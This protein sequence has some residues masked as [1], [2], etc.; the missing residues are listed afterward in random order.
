MRRQ[1]QNNRN[2]AGN[3]LIFLIK[4]RW[5]FGCLL[6]FCI[7][8]RNTTTIPATGSDRII[9]TEDLRAIDS[10]RALISTGDIIFRNGTDEVSAAARSFN[11]TDTNYSH[12][13]IIQVEND[14]VFVYHAI[15]GSY[16]PDKKLRR[17]PIDS[18]CSP[19]ENDKFA[20]YR[21]ALQPAQHD[22]LTAIVTRYYRAGLR[23]DMYFNYKTDNVMYCSEFVFKCLNRSMSDSLTPYLRLTN[24]YFDVTP[25]D[26]FLNP[27]STLIKRVDFTR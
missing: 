11:R 3:K 21:Y 24:G 6:F 19:L 10:T 9:N 15:G 23:F 14:T 8:C 7:A 22:S 1:R 25:D 16:N 18:F 12:C 2:N 4:Q 13:G 20:V 17:D 27:Y 5:P 26:I